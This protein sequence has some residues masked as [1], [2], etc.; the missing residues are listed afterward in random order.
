MLARSRRNRERDLIVVSRKYFMRINKFSVPLAQLIFMLWAFGCISAQA[1][2][3]ELYERDN[4]HLGLR[5]S[6]PASEVDKL[7]AQQLLSTPGMLPTTNA[8]NLLALPLDAAPVIGAYLKAARLSRG[9][10]VHLPAFCPEGDCSKVTFTVRARHIM[11]GAK[12]ARKSMSINGRD[13]A[14]AS[15]FFTNETQPRLVSALYIGPE[16]SDSA[17]RQLTNSFAAIRREYRSIA[18][19]DLLAGVGMIATTATNS[20]GYRGFGGDILNIVRMTYDEPRELAEKEIV[21]EFINTFSHELAH[22]L[23]S[24]RLFELPQGRLVVEGSAEFFKIMVL[25]RTLLADEAT[26]TSLVTRA[27]D[28]CARQRGPSGLLERVAKDTADYREYYDCGLINYFSLL[29]DSAGGEKKFVGSVLAALHNPDATATDEMRSCL[30]MSASCAHPVLTKML[31]DSNSL[32]AQRAWFISRWT[33]YLRAG[34]VVPATIQ[35]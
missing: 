19:R 18:G 1:L 35:R 33:D 26:L 2:N 27:Y 25:K 14:N 28:E 9:V 31:Q 17:A 12:V 11:F 29:L 30:L 16:F 6:K 20:K 8:T 10:Y 21:R 4:E 13:A 34:D 22:K 5:L 24:P 23:Q 3:I 15:I 32:E 7:F